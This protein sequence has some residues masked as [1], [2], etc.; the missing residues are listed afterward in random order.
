MK[1]LYSNNLRN[2]YVRIILI[3]KL[4]D[5]NEMGEPYR[6]YGGSMSVQYFG[7]KVSGTVSLH[8]YLLVTSFVQIK[9]LTK[10]ICK[11]RLDAF[12]FL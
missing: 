1:N 9:R 7:R 12:Q 8:S 3:R 11:S 2:F 5:D 10:Q 4:R 6:M